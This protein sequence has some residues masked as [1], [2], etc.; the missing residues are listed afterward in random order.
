MKTKII[1][2]QFILFLL[3]ILTLPAL[4]SDNIS[5]DYLL[6]RFN[7]AKRNDFQ[8]IPAQ[9]LYHKN[10]VMYLRKETLHS[11]LKMAKA[12]EQDGVKLRIIS[13]TRNFW[14]QKY[15]W[16]A[17]WNGKRKVEGKNLA[18]SGLNDIKKAKT[19][20]RYSSMPGTSRHH[21]GTDFDINSLNNHYF[22]HGYGKKVYHWL[23]AN[24]HRYGFC[25]PYSVKG[26][27][28]PFGYE[29]EKW[30]WSYK[31]ISSQ[32]LKAYNLNING[33]KIQGFSGHEQTRALKILEHYVNGIHPECK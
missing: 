27:N 13:A 14:T 7:P 10:R 2:N 3:L 12:A 5:K 21:W 15:I 16:E 17:K 32:Y 18:T 30:H 23:R 11:F 9:Y 33:D 20:L 19:I 31:P 28:R 6:G 29:E 26:K 24:A 22:S 8:K 1:A 4:S 25:Q